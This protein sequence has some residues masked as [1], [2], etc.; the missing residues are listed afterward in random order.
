[1]LRLLL[2]AAATSCASAIDW[3]QTKCQVHAALLRAWTFKNCRGSSGVQNGNRN[4]R[5]EYHWFMAY[6]VTVMEDGVNG[7]G[8]RRQPL[9]CQNYDEENQRCRCELDCLYVFHSFSEQ[10]WSD[11]CMR[12]NGKCGT[13]HGQV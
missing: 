1:M 7:T 9:A 10:L 4:C 12:R 6:D 2:A 3:Q 11:P 13:E 8:G 5:Q